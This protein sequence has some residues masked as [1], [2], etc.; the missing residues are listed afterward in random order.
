MT[1]GQTSDSGY[2]QC[3]SSAICVVS[4]NHKA[5]RADGPLAHSIKRAVMLPRKV[6]LRL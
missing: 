3:G 5:L 2:V 4:L 6:F 1:R